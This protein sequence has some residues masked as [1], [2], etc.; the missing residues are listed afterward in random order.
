MVIENEMS[1]TQEI[2]T[3]DPQGSVLGPLLFRI[4]INYLNTCIQFSK[5]YHFANDTNIMY[6]KKS[7]EIFFFFFLWVSKHRWAPSGVWAG[8]L[9]ILDVTIIFCPITS[10]TDTQFSLNYKQNNLH[11]PDQSANKYIP[12]STFR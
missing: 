10:I 2:L 5:T 8:N 6:S 1:S 11:A 3:G 12:R 9:P 4:Y 7:L